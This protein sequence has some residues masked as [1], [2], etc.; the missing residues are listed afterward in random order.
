MKGL[1]IKERRI[2]VRTRRNYLAYVKTNC[3]KDKPNAALR[4]ESG[5]SA[6]VLV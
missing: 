4:D 1:E 5:A 3:M 6:N 2:V